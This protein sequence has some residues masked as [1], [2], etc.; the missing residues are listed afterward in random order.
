MSFICNEHKQK[1]TK[2]FKHK[3]TIMKQ[4]LALMIFISFS[5]LTYGQTEPA[6]NGID[7]TKISS[8][9]NNLIYENSKAFP[10]NTELAIAMIENGE[11]RF[12]GIKRVNDTIITIENKN[13]I[14]EIGSISK[15]LTAT[16]LAHFVNEGKMK[17][18]D[19]IQHYLDF[20]LNF[21][22]TITLQNLSNHT[23]GLPRMPSNFNIFTIKDIKNPFKDYDTVKLKKYLTKKAKLIQE[24]GTT[25]SYSNLGAGLLGYILSETSNSTYEELLQENIFSKYGMDNSTTIRKNI[26]KNLVKGL[27]RKGKETS[28]WDFDVMISAGGIL[29]SVYDLSKFAHAQFDD[30]NKDLLMTQQPTFI[31]SEKLSFGLG[32]HIVK[33]KNGENLLWHNGGTG[34]YSSSMILDKENRT[35]VI[36]LSNVSAYNKLSG[37]TD[38]LGLGLI[39]TLG[40]EQ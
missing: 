20:E 4:I 3:N 8:E 23:S 28:N 32:W 14:F 10:N 29:S 6:V 5:I 21:E 2:L 25:Y 13:H 36:I 19:P 26:E 18:D 1:I 17:L 22:D 31:F 16:L 27:S 24:P 37:N 33:T 9:Q 15:V 11:T 38:K 39:G 40:G 7:S 12:F 35:G 34:G 30:E